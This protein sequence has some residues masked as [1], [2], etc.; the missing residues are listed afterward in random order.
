MRYL[1]ALFLPQ[2]LRLFFLLAPNPRFLLLA[3]HLLLVKPRQPLCL[4]MLQGTINW[5][6]R[7]FAALLG[8]L[9]GT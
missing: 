6:T 2:A 1:L 3:K 5:L 4:Q 7:L 9:V 8:Q